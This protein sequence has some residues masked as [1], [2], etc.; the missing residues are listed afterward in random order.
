MNNPYT[1]SVY[2]MTHGYAK[3]ENFIYPECVIVSSPPP[4]L[5]EDW[6]DSVSEPSPDELVVMNRNARLLL[7]DFLN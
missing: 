6:I 4:D 2:C 5:P 7:D 3:V 1:K